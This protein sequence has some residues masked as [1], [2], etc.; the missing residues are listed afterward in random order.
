MDA[1]VLFESCLNGTK[2]AVPR[3]PRKDELS[4]LISNGNI[5][6]YQ[7]TTSDIHQWRDG[8][9]WHRVLQPYKLNKFIIYR[10]LVEKAYCDTGMTKAPEIKKGGL[11]KRVLA[12]KHNGIQHSLVSYY[13]EDMENKLPRPSECL[14]VTLRDGL[15]S[16]GGGQRTVLERISTPGY[17]KGKKRKR[18]TRAAKGNICQYIINN[19]KCSQTDISAQFHVP[20]R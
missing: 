20:K 3:K 9:S 16:D 11:V 19:P 15:I 10:E 13:M 5:F 14:Q 8:L 6:V 2:T 12:V 7:E 4:S 17:Q 18:L 1:L